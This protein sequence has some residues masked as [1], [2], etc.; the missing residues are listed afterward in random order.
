MKTINTSVNITGGG[1]NLDEAIDQSMK[2][3]RI[4]PRTHG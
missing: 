2:K 1:G 3:K 4:D